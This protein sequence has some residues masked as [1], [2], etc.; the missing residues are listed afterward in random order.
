MPNLNRIDDIGDITDA[1][2]EKLLREVVNDAVTSLENSENIN[3]RS[4]YNGQSREIIL[5]GMVK[6]AQA[7]HGVS[8]F[9][10]SIENFNEY[11]LTSTY[12]GSTLSNRIY[13]DSQRAQRALEK[14]VK[15]HIKDKTNWQRLTKD[16]K[17]NVIPKGDVPQYIKDVEEAFKKADVTGLKKAIRKANRRIEMFTDKDGITKS[18]LRR[19]YADVVKAAE[20]GDA[21]LLKK[22]MSTAV[23]KKAIN[24]SQRLARSELSR[25]YMDAELR[26]IQDD[27]DMIGWR[28]I[29]S[30]QHPRPDICD[31]MAQAD[32]YGM[33]AG[34]FPKSMGSP[35][36]HHPGCICMVAGVLRQDGD[37]SG[38]HSK[39]RVKEYL[40]GLKNGGAKSREKLK[41][42][43]GV[44]GSMNIN[45]WERY[46]R[47]WKGVQSLTPTPQDLIQRE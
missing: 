17:K 15:Q 12:N 32:Q 47:N 36:P 42:I 39:T 30:P 43:L 35:L 33:G 40:T 13:R 27:V 41:G 44:E 8:Y 25:A 16:I 19:A 28:S 29:L 4:L 37:R 38:R 9:I 26:R 2:F 18:N 14:T 46:M 34:V 23:E 22:K 45:E 24:N 5:D 21:A 31:F 10:P 7:G 1:E 11:Y 20:K 3:I 6:S